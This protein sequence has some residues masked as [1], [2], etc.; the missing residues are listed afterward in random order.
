MMMATAGAAEAAAA[1]KVYLIFWIA[2]E[3]FRLRKFCEE[4]LLL[5]EKFGVAFLQGAQLVYVRTGWGLMMPFDAMQPDDIEWGA[6][7]LLGKV[8]Y[9]FIRPLLFIETF[10]KG[11]VGVGN[12]LSSAVMLSRDG[13]RHHVSCPGL[14]WIEDGF[15]E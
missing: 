9:D 15:I 6:A 10:I 11:S 2:L 1:R 7:G 12:F 4:S 5:V 14:D 13:C 8:L 3:K